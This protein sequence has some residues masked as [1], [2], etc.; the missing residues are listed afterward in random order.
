[1]D[2][3]TGV[4][5]N[6]N[7][8]V[9]LLKDRLIPALKDL[10]DGLEAIRYN[11]VA[12]E[13]LWRDY[14]L[15]AGPAQGP[16]A[17]VLGLR[18][19]V[20]LEGVAFTYPGG[21]QAA[22]AGIDL[23]IAAGRS[24]CFVGTTGAGKSTTLD[25]LLGLLQPSAGRMLV[26][27]R[28]LDDAELRAWQRGIGYCPQAVLLLDDTVASNIAF[29]ID[30]DRIEPARLERAARIAGIHDFIAGDLPEGYQTLVGE[31]GASLSGGQRQRIGI[32][33]ALYRDAPVLVLDEATNELDPVTEARILQNL[34]ELGGRTLIFVSHRAS[35][36]SFCD[37][38]AV[39]EDGR[40][41]AQADY[42]SLAAPGSPYRSLLEE[43]AS[44]P[45]A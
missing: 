26:D 5:S 6:G 16:D 39:F 14:S 37:T 36:A 27:G 20:R 21:R 34:R 41:I 43:T 35:V 44:C 12:L 29:G 2:V 9:A 33:R 19:S 10:F 32:A 28:P 42:R 18:E 25:I 24:H 4:F 22:L 31:R 8:V 40:V 13:P 7:R 3:V 45:S 1:M 23:E 38:V 11:M 17:G 30:P 15:P